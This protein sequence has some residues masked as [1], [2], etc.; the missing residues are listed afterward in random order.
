MCSFEKITL[1]NNKVKLSSYKTAKT[2]TNLIQ[3][4]SQTIASKTSFFG[5]NEDLMNRFFV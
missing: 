1:Q 2:I 5:V 4:H 3:E